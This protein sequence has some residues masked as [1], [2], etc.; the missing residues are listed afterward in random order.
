VSAR[1]AFSYA[2]IR[3]VPHVER[4][5]SFNA[6]VVLFCR[7]LGFLGARVA[8]DENRLAALGPDISPE[9]VWPLLQTIVR[10]AEGDPQ[11]GA[12]AALPPSERFGWLVAPSSTIIQPSPA[13]TGLCEDAG[14][15]LD[16]LFADL[17]G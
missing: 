3:V 16:E 1:R 15:T 8:L 5:E 9:I 12:I 2:I 6:G 14:V 4:G 11:A 10:V 17:V 13:H 7:Q